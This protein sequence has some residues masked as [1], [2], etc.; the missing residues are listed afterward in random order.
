MVK[1]IR[2]EFKASGCS[3][4]IHTSMVYDRNTYLLLLF[5]IS[6]NKEREIEPPRRVEWEHSLSISLTGGEC[7]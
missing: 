7:H 3:G 1:K 5:E 4:Q 2:E 6:Q